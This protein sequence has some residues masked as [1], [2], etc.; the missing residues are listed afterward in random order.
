MI[1]R[2]PY[3][4]DEVVARLGR[5]LLILHGRG[6]DIIPVAHGRRLHELAKGSTYVEMDAAHNDFPRDWNEYG[7]ALGGFL[8]ASGLMPAR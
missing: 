8:S 7:R 6:D 3:R 2:H 5:P 1:C 4:T